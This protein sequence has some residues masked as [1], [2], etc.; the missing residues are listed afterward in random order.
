[1]KRTR[2]LVAALLCLALVLPL[3]AGAEDTLLRGTLR[4][5]PEGQEMFIDVVLFRWE[6]ILSLWYAPEDFV[7]MVTRQGLRFDLIDNE[8]GQPVFFRVESHFDP[9]GYT[10]GTLA[11]I[12]AVYEQAGWA[13]EPL[14]TKGRL[15]DFRQEPPEGFIA[16][17]D[18]QV[19]QVL[20][21]QV[22]SGAYAVTM[23]S[24]EEASEGWGARMQ[25][26]LDTL[27]VLPGQ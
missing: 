16:R 2:W 11:D 9:S 6:G 22:A 14:D 10:P 26:M 13:C 25:Q 4:L 24:P 8:L 19:A 3:G 1:M 20:V 21:T 18:S 7:P 15:P 17:R 23:Q 27:T 5:M 12:Q